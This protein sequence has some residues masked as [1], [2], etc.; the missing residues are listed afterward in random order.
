MSGNCAGKSRV[1]KPLKGLLIKTGSGTFGDAAVLKFAV[2]FSD[3][4]GDGLPAVPAISG[5]VGRCMG[6]DVF[7]K[8]IQKFLLNIRNHQKFLFFAVF[9]NGQGHAADGEIKIKLCQGFLVKRFSH[10]C[11]GTEV[12]SDFL[13]KPEFAVCPEEFLEVQRIKGEKVK[14]AGTVMR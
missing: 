12:A 6:G 4:C 7:Q 13:R 8:Q 5:I 2:G 14:V 11:S 3:L 1:Y 10:R 9:Q